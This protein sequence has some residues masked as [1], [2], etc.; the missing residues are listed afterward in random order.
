MARAAEV[1]YT[2]KSLIEVFEDAFMSR[3]YSRTY[4]ENWLEKFFA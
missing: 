4:Y 1:C 2:E 3:V